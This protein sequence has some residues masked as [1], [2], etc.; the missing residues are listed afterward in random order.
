MKQKLLLVP[1]CFDPELDSTEKIAE[2]ALGKEKIKQYDKIKSLSNMGGIGFYASIDDGFNH[3]YH[4]LSVLEKKYFM[5]ILA[6][7]HTNCKHPRYLNNDELGI[8]DVK[9]FT[10]HAHDLFK[11]KI[12]PCQ[13]ILKN[14][15]INPILI[16]EQEKLQL[17]K[18]TSPT[19]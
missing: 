9:F 6:T 5:E 13:I 1:H 7:C 12:Y 17:L 3:L 19:I 4:Q 15:Q 11:I 2:N 14:G 10:V 18:R 8:I 16:S